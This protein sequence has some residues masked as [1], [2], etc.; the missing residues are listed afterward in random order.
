MTRLLFLLICGLFSCQNSNN[1]QLEATNEIVTESSHSVPTEPGDDTINT[2]RIKHIRFLYNK[3]P[4]IN[5]PFHYKTQTSL[6]VTNFDA[7]YGVDTL[8]F[9][10]HAPCGI[11]GVM[12]DTSAFFGFFYLI[13]A[14]D[15]T[16]A[17]I[18]FDKKGHLI[19]KKALTRSCWQ[20]CESDCRS[21]IDIDLDYKITFRYEE[22]EF[23]FKE[24]YSYCAERPNEAKGYI[25]YSHISPDGKV[26][27]DKI[28]SLSFEV[29]MKNPILHEE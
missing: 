7:K 20:G 18:T 8:V 12:P 5:L 16:P 19:E 4:I 26:I 1:K 6:A 21:L 24:D 17:I 23:D 14:D 3:Y 22:Y 2:D 25:E 11:I 9:G 13:A 10:D 28:D 27:K 15:A 29:L